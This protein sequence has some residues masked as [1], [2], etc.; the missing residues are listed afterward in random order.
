MSRERIVKISLTQELAE[1]IFKNVWIVL[2]ISEGPQCTRVVKVCESK[3][4]ARDY[5]I[6]H[7]SDETPLRY[8]NCYLGTTKK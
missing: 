1:A 7:D 2:D 3:E 4:H 5:C 6:I 8:Y